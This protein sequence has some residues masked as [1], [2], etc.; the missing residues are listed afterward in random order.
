MRNELLKELIKIRLGLVWGGLVWRMRSRVGSGW[1]GEK[2][3]ETRKM[4]RCGVVATGRRRRLLFGI[5]TTPRS[6]PQF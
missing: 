1:K 2:E 4:L 6:P 5:S 3:V